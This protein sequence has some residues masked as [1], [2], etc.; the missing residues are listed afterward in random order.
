MQSLP[1]FFGQNSG[2]LIFSKFPIISSQ[3]EI[4]QTSSI[5]EYPNNK[6]FVLADIEICEGK[7]ITV[8]TAHLDAHFH[9]TTREA[10]VKQ[11]ADAM[12]PKYN[13]GIPLMMMGDL[14]ICPRCKP[15]EYAYLRDTM[16]ELGLEDI[17]PN[18]AVTHVLGAT[19]DHIFFSK[20]SWDASLSSVEYWK[21]EEA[22]MLSDHYAVIGKFSLGE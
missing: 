15:G 8:C 9:S 17:V 12:Q 10:Q 13:E 2:L 16:K 6:G 19:L 1:K 14:N 5:T 18:D 4:F 3:S 22:G 7:I 21:D 11:I 20:S